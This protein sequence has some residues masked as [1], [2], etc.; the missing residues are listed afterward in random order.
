M[1]L[2]GVSFLVLGLALATAARAETPLESSFAGGYLASRSASQLHDIGATIQ[3]TH[4]ALAYDQ[5]NVVLNERLFQAQVMAGDIAKAEP[6]AGQVIKANSQHRMARL[7]LG[8]KDF[9]ARR[10]Q[11]ARDHFNEAAYTPLG[12]LTSALLSAWTYAGEGS[13]NAALHELDK[14]DGQE[15]FAN[16]KAFHAA[17]IA[18]FLGSSMRAE[19]AYKKAYDLAPNSLRIVQAYGNFLERNG[20]KDQAI[21]IYQAYLADGQRD[22]LV[23]NALDKASGTTKPLP[24]VG[25]A[26]AGAG[27]VLFS[28]A[29]ALN[30]DQ[31]SDSALM[32]SQLAVGLSSD[33]P[34]ILTTVGG[35]QAD[36]KDYEASNKTYDQ[37]PK[38]SVL[39][40]YADTQIAVNLQRNGKNPE[41]IE[42][43]KTVLTKDPKNYDA[44]VT[45][46]SIYRTTDDFPKAEEAFTQAL[47]LLSP[48]D[49]NAWKLYYD[50]G[51]AFDRAKEF[52]KAEA[53]FRKALTL[54]K[55][56]PAVLNYLGYSM[57]DRGVHL[58]E[59]MAMIKKA[60]DLK[61][62]DG[63]IVDSLGWAY[64]TLRD[65]EQA[66][67][68]CERAVD[69]NPADPII[70]EHLG[71]AYWRAGRKLEAQFQWNHARANHPD[72]D[73]LTRIEGKIKSG[74]VDE[75]AIV[76]KKG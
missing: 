45:L 62:N 15:A 25:S 67:N 26:A 54:S 22:I 11:E 3:Y 56:D 29:G 61:P 21:K 60:V 55:D 14:L 59:A 34:V 4:D 71:D 53:D 42:K 19:P 9:R 68:Y 31:N 23:R 39:R 28:L 17:L 46:G 63:F 7:V 41:A 70:S 65:Y 32:Y 12:E 27:E 48:D 13:V 10:Y 74:L 6:L 43:L 47:Q 50:R 33:K 36:L 37:I 73:D 38:D 51:I 18:D 52:D 69:L 1:V 2:R 5:N 16:Y 30:G 8:L 20:H 44:L 40:N 49:P 72:K 24:F 66:V 64:Y 76:P 75:P 35:A 57:I 58:D